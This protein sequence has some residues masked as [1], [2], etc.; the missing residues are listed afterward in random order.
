[1]YSTLII[2]RHC[3]HHH[4]TH[5]YPP[6]ESSKS[7]EVERRLVETERIQ[8]TKM[9]VLQQKLQEETERRWLLYSINAACTND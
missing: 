5:E 9:T 6:I 1:M 2:V 4:C 7:N 8:A 3:V